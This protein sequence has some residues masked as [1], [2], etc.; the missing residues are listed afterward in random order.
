MTSE[1]GGNKMAMSFD[2]KYTQCI[3]NLKN[4]DMPDC[5]RDE[6]SLFADF[7]ELLVI[8]SK[9]DGIAYGDIQ[10]RFFGEP[11]EKNTSERNDANESFI[12]GIFSLIEERRVLYRNLYPFDI[13]NKQIITLKKDLSLPQKL[14]VFLLLSSSLD[15]FKSFNAEITTDFEMV[16][17]EAIKS[18]M[19]NAVVKSFGKLSEYEGTAIE[20][21]R[22]LAD[23]IC[24]PTDDHE[25]GCI[26]E[27]NVQE[28]GLDIVS[29]IPFDDK[30]QNKI[31]YLCQCACGKQYEYKQHDIRRFEHYY[32]FY[33]TKPQRTLFV[34][35]AL[36]NPKDGKFY[37]S[38]YI[39]DGYL[40]FER[41]RI[42]NLAKRKEDVLTLLKSTDLVERCIQDYC[43]HTETVI[44]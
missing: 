37:H 28:R 33:K 31:I 25:I 6:T 1:R 21:I 24:L 12:D 2:E 38:D 44:I 4:V 14:Y 35:Y 16:S 11:D 3:R 23:D 34:P 20:K 15:I 30:C 26:G 18:F 42:I 7:V 36:I 5:S 22:K 19:P 27:K 9:G 39:E 43:T 17:Y 13:G 32:R 41:L 40:I 8:F 29:W 10:D